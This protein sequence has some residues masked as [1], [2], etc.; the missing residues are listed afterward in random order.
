MSDPTP[1]V[2]ASPAPAGGDRRPLDR[3]PG[4]RYGSGSSGTGAGPN[5]GSGP[6][7]PRGPAGSVP[8]GSGTARALVAGMLVADAG[9]IL[10]FALG[11]LDLGVGL[12]AVAAFTG[13]ATALALVWWGRRAIPDART[14]VTVGAVLGGWT[15]VGG[16]IVDWLY[17][18]VQGGSLGPLDYVAQR[19]GMVALLA[20]VVAAAVAAVRSR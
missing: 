20:L 8:G 16:I 4:E 9:A 5:G 11:L 7:R 19:Y 3:P 12:V 15:V 6:G 1:P 2:S 10:F 18:L 13:W 17:A 14:R